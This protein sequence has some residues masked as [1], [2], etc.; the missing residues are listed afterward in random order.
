[1][2]TRVFA[3]IRIRQNLCVPYIRAYKY[4]RIRVKYAA[5]PTPNILVFD[6]ILSTVLI[7]MQ[8][9]YTT[10]DIVERVG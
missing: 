7:I 2:S 6:V 9:L 3:Y 10:H 5:Y 4:A 8:Y 1:M